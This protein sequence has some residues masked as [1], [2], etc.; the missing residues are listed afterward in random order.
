M[1][2]YLKEVLEKLKENANG[3]RLVFENNGK[4]LNEGTFNT[5]LS[6]FREGGDDLYYQLSPANIR[7]GL[8]KYLLWN[9]YPLEKIF[10]LM[11][12]DGKKLESYITTAEITKA[13][14]NNSNKLNC[15]MVQHPLEEFFEELR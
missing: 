6:G 12:I 11:D 13:E 1:P 8:A 15:S 3:C 2:T 9:G 14:W 10:Y 4:P 7:R 5:I